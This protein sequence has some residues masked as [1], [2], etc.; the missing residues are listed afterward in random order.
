M[1]VKSYPLCLSIVF[2]FYILPTMATV[3]NYYNASHNITLIDSNFN[4][5]CSISIISIHTR[6]ILKPSTNLDL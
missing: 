5:D 3:T 4:K 2:T 6:P 1:V